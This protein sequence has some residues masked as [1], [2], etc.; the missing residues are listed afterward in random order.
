MA[1]NQVIGMYCP[2]TSEIIEIYTARPRDTRIL[3]PEKNCAGQ[4]RAS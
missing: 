4:N 3:V 2:M 1:G